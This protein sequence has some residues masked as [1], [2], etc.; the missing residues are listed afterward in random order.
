MALAGA[1]MD[2]ALHQRFNPKEYYRRFLEYGVRPDGRPLH[3]LRRSHLHRSA[4]GS[5]HG[6]ASISFGQS[7]FVAGVRAEVTEA[8]PELPVCG[9]IAVTVDLPALCASSFREK[10]RSLG[11]STF[12][13]TALVDILNNSRV[14][15]P[16][17]LL[18]RDGELF[19]VLHIHVICL[20][21]D[22]NAFDLS[23]LAAVAALEDT[24]LPAL[25]MDQSP[26]SNDSRRLVEAPVDAVNVVSES[27][28]VLLASR[29]LPMTFAQLAGQQ[30]V[31]DPCAAEEGLGTSVSLCLV[32]GR[33][34]VFHQG[35]SAEV[36]RFVGE[37]MPMARSCVHVLTKLLDAARLPLEECCIAMA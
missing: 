1:D 11:H 9:H 32:G 21:F 3:G 28:R 14:F 4:I 29:P 35:G 5:A 12:L 36:E 13:S 18:V 31:L 22:G 30:W 24:I 8:A 37:L 7:A 26:G 6:S 25:A 2:A 16:A 17:Q 15:D 27:R 34:L 19:W 23:L 33:W 10:H 20:N